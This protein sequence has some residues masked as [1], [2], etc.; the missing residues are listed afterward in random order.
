MKL[1]QLV[2]TI[3]DVENRAEVREQQLEKG[4]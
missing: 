2:G 3:E 1:I 4:R